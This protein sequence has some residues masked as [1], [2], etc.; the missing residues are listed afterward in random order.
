MEAEVHQPKQNKTGRHTHLRAKQLKGRLREAYPINVYIPLNP[1][2]WDKL[3]Q[4]V[5][6]M[7]ESSTLPTKLSQTVLVL[8]PKGNAYIRG[9]GLLEVL[10]K[11]VEAVTTLS[12]M[13]SVPV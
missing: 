11:V 2:R 4:L 8:L 7:W 9:I 1:L 10:C 6:H 5:Q 13:D 12:Y 3:V